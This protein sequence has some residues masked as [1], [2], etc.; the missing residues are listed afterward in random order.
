MLKG[1]RTFI[2][3]ETGRNRRKVKEVQNKLVH[4]HKYKHRGAVFALSQLTSLTDAHP[5]THT[6]QGV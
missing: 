4:G 6:H 2:T 3:A 1:I 5:R